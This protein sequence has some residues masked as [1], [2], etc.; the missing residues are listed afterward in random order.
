MRI[1]YNS[2]TRAIAC[3]TLAV[4]LL[5]FLTGSSTIAT[6]QE[7]PPVITVLVVEN[8]IIGDRWPAGASVTLTIEDPDTASSPDY[9]ATEVVPYDGAHVW[10]PLQ[11]A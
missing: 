3:C 10:F 7:Y 11:E 8:R 2:R 1:N 6:A 5:G 9:T 4:A